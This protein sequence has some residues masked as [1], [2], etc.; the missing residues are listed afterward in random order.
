MSF[1][2]AARSGQRQPERAGHR[3]FRPAGIRRAMLARHRATSPATLSPIDPPAIGATIASNNAD[4]R[5]GTRLT[6]SSSRAAAQPNDCVARAAVPDHGVGGV[7]GL[8][9][10][11]V[12]AARA[13]PART[14]APPRR[15][16]NSRRRIRSRRG[17]RR[18]HRVAPD[19]G[20]R[21]WRR[22]RAP[23]RARP[24]R[25]PRAPGRHADRGFAAR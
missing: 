25:T 7:D 5:A 18:P 13:A 8:V 22:P 21:S 14:P 9:G 2:I 15:R 10:D 3:A 19:R 4:N 1:G 23:R 17:T 6:R 12:R 11:Q 16:R 20:R 24:R